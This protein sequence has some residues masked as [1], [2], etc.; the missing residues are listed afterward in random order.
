MK[1]NQAEADK[2]NRAAQ[3]CV[4][5][6]HKA[7]DASGIDADGFAADI[8]ARVIQTSVIQTAS[9]QSSLVPQAVVRTFASIGGDVGGDASFAFAHAAIVHGFMGDDLPEWLESHEYNYEVG[10]DI[11]TLVD[12]MLED[13]S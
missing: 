1:Y 10:G 4:R 7:K 2:V 5:R 11:R 13:E 6:L 3:E 8:A 9:W 12:A